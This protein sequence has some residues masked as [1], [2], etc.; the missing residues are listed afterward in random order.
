[1]KRGGGGAGE[2]VLGAIAVGGG[3]D[4]GVEAAER[5]LSAVRLMPPSVS[6][7]SGT[8]WLP[9]ATVWRRRRSRGRHEPSPHVA[10]A[11]TRALSRRVRS[12]VASL[13]PHH[14]QGGGWAFSPSTL[15]AAVLRIASQVRC[16]AGPTPK[17]SPAQTPSSTEK[18]W[19]TPTRSPVTQNEYDAP[20]T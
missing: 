16:A 18:R 15:H 8:T 7:M 12:R 20:R 1:M 11:D 10:V 4:F 14:P 9:L 5:V 6:E 19:Y 2:A 13:P 3:G 17:A